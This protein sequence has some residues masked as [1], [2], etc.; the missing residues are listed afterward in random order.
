[1]KNNH[2]I[3]VML[4][5]FIILSLIA[6]YISSDLVMVVKGENTDPVLSE[7]GA[8]IQEGE[9]GQEYFFTVTYTD[10]DGDEGIVLLHI[11]SNDPI[12]MRTLD[13]DPKEGQ[14]YEI[15]FSDIKLDD[16]SEFRFSG[17]D[18]NGS[19]AYLPAQTED[20]FLFGD[21]DGWGEPPVLS[22]PDVYF[23]GDDW[24]F[25]VT[26]QDPDG[27]EV[28]NL[29]LILNDVDYISME[30]TDTD[31]LSGQNY[32]ARV[33]ENDVTE[34]TEFYFSVDDENG[35]YTDLYEEDSN[36]F[37][38]QDFKR[39][40]GNGGTGNG[41]GVSKDESKTNETV[42]NPFEGWLDNPEVVVGMFGLIA[43][44]AGSAYGIYRSRKKQGRFSKLLT[45]LDDVYSSYKMNPR[46]CETELENMKS[47]INEDLKKGVIDENNYTILKG[48]IDEFLS[49]IHSE[50]IHPGI[51]KLSKDI[52]RKN[53]NNPVDDK[54]SK[55]KQANLKELPWEQ[56]EKLIKKW[57]KQNWNEDV[58]KVK[59]LSEGGVEE[60]EVPQYTDGHTP[61]ST[62]IKSFTYIARVKAK[63]PTGKVG[64]YKINFHFEKGEGGWRIK[65]AGVM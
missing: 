48:R 58:I 49:E 51:T 12:T 4:S 35:S 18:Q 30:T 23:D 14:Y 32:K 42:A 65:L 3:I 27:D 59:Q 10:P 46:R 45:R 37:L 9:S 44:G 28:E 53:K 43:V 17:D 21:F 22:S 11:D 24:I 57:V 7:V 1:M 33:L 6:T 5:G 63:K 55:E 19:T 41:G 26:Y 34:L 40:N 20:P 2:S 47:T 60:T 61:E 15:T 50:A 16:N 29:Y 13:Q 8:Y 56:A 39:D 31:P 64:D 25:N 38:V 54:T 52:K 36:M 62:T